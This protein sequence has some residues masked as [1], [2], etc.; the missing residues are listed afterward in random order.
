VLPFAT[1]GFGRV[2]DASLLDDAVTSVAASA[3]RGLL[4]AQGIR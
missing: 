1:D 2:P 4:G 3:V